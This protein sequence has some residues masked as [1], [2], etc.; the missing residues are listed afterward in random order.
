MDIADGCVLLDRDVSATIEL[1]WAILAEA[2]ELWASRTYISGRA[3]LDDFDIADLLLVV[4]HNVSV[5]DGSTPEEI[6]VAAGDA[7]ATEVMDRLNKPWPVLFDRPGEVL[8]I[9]L[10]DGEVLWCSGTRPA[11]PLG[12]L[13][14]ESLS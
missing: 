9:A 2:K 10:L 13:G 8:E 4:D 1:P 3:D 7:L 14:T 5:L 6:L 11:R 12:S